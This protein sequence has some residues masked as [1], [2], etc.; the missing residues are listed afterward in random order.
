[1]GE[2]GRT[3][4]VLRGNAPA[5]APPGAA[6]ARGV[7]RAGTGKIGARMI[8]ILF[9]SALLIGGLLS[10]M[11]AAPGARA[12]P[13]D[14]DAGAGAAPVPRPL[15]PPR[16]PAREAAALRDALYAAVNRARRRAGAAALTRDTG[17]EDIAGRHAD[18][19]AA[20]GYVA[21]VSPEGDGP[22]ERLTARFPDYV[23][24]IGEN[25]AVRARTA[26]MP[27]TRVATQAVEAWLE[28][29]PHRANLL[30]PRHSH[31][32]LAAASGPVAVYVVMLM[33]SE[34]SLSAP[35]DAPP[36]PGTVIRDGD[37]PTP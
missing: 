35:A 20:R 33:G 29:A 23:G 12:A 17:L 6:L 13:G 15:P 16:R 32:G 7:P 1:M 31:V 26:N 10:F 9:I 36:P 3:G 22:R 5:A 14:T 25:I 37:A 21:H 24:V 34:S 27:A 2:R 8:G 28:S 19:M 11:A 30:D 18:D 4:A